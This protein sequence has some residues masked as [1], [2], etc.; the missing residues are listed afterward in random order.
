MGRLMRK[1]LSQGKLATSI[2]PSTGPHIMPRAT[3]V[4]RMPMARPRSRAGNDSVIMPMLLAM[5]AA[6]PTPWT[7]RARIRTSSEADSPHSNDP[8]VKTI[9]PSWN[10][11]TLPRTSPKRPNGSIATHVASR[12]TELT[13]W[14]WSRPTPSSFCITGNATVTTV[15]SRHD[16]NVMMSTVNRIAHLFLPWVSPSRAMCSRRSCSA[17][18]SISILSSGPTQKRGPNRLQTVAIGVPPT[19]SERKVTE[20]FC[21]HRRLVRTLA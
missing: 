12:Y 8:T 1:I 5:A 13:N 4:A 9:T 15:E 3:K 19:E 6:Q 16:I 18:F 7:M 10:T 2:P 14:M 11:P 17:V 21:Q 20:A